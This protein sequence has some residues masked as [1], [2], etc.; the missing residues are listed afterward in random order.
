MIWMLP[1]G[2]LYSYDM[3]Y[4]LGIH[5]AYGQYPRILSRSGDLLGWGREG[6][7]GPIAGSGDI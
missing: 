1:D 5:E 3:I 6:V 4:F 7:Y 2:S